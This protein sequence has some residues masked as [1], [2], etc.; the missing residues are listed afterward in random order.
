[1]IDEI[2]IENPDN[3]KAAIGAVEGRGGTVVCVYTSFVLR[4]SEVNYIPL[5]RIVVRCPPTEGPDAINE[6]VSAA[7]SSNKHGDN[8][9]AK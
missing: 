5:Y 8:G 1:M 4:H 2:Q 7:I 6:A 3:I 9:K